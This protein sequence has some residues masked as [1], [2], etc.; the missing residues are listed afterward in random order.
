MWAWN[1]KKG[2]M[3][4][5]WNDSLDKAYKQPR[6]TDTNGFRFSHRAGK[7]CIMSSGFKEV[8]N[9]TEKRITDLY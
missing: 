3:F 1:I 9:Y 7:R 2:F 8:T 4:C 6:E 5:P